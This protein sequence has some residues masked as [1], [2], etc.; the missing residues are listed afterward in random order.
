[1]SCT[2]YDKAIPALKYHAMRVYRESGG[3][4]P[5]IFNLK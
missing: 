2:T 3:K 4:E 1:M 5:H